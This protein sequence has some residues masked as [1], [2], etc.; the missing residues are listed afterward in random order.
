M[1]HVGLAQNQSDIG[2][3]DEEPVAI[4][5]VGLAFLADL[6]PRYD[7][8]DELEV[9]V[10]DR[11]GALIAARANGDRHVRLGLLA[12]VDRPEPRRSAPRALECGLLRA[13]LARAQLV[14]SEPRHGDLLDAVAVGL[15]DV[16]DFRRLPQELQEFDAAQLD[17]PRVELRQRRVRQLAFDLLDVLLDSRRR[18]DRLFMLEARERRL[19]FLIREIDADAPRGKQRRRH[20][21]EDQQQVFAK[22]PA[23]MG[24][25]VGRVRGGG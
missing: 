23:A 1:R 21:R 2:V 16:G 10:G 14:H 22:E 11:H 12:E 9:H 7:I 18:G 13:I 20:Q 6:D 19:A 8:P 17:V 4:D 25:R 3:G 24:P 15:R 5:D